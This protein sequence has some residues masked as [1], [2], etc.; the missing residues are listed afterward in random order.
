MSL[1]PELE[2]EH[3]VPQAGQPRSTYFWKE[4]KQMSGDRE[5]NL[6]PLGAILKA[7]ERALSEAR[8]TALRDA[9]TAIEA[10]PGI[11]DAWVNVNDLITQTEFSQ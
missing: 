4:N 10:S 9:M 7:A 3:G 1:A 11:T 6:T 5:A 2:N 8:V